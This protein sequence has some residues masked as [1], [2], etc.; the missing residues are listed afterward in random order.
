M[1]KVGV[2][3]CISLN[4]EIVP[5][6]FS[7]G[8]DRKALRMLQALKPNILL[9]NANGR[10]IWVEGFLHDKEAHTEL[11][12]GEPA[13]KVRVLTLKHWYIQTP[14]V[15]WVG[16]INRSRDEAAVRAPSIQRSGLSPSDFFGLSNPWD[17]DYSGYQR[18]DSAP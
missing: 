9:P 2:Q 12:P 1:D 4:G 16:Q 3:T 5:V 13:E 11:K 10:G 7:E 15:E 17:I 6:V 14:F 8:S 18:E